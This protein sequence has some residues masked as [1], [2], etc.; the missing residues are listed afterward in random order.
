MKL[1]GIIRRD[2]QMVADAVTETHYETPA[3]VDN[4][5]DVIGELCAAFDLPR[6]VILKKHVRELREFSHTVFK[7]QDFIEPIDFDRFEI[8]IFYDKDKKK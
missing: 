3:L 7:A 1:W 5:S 8:S 6:P 4:W 2:N